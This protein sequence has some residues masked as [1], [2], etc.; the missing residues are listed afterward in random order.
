MAES[1]AV[2]PM[3]RPAGESS[4]AVA[5]GSKRTNGPHVPITAM[6]GRVRARPP[7]SRA[8]SGS[9]RRSRRAPQDRHHARLS[10]GYFSDDS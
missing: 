5:S 4:V 8:C 9:R 7:T 6:H 2:D 10:A 3:A 1:R